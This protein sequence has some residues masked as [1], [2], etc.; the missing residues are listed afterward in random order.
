MSRYFDRFS[1]RVSHLSGTAHA[2]IFA[3]ALI[4]LW[5]ASGPW[6][7]YSELWQLSVN[8]ATTIVTFLMV[9]VVQHTQNRDTLALHA[10]L[11]ELIYATK[12]AR[13]DLIEVE[14]QTE[15][16]IQHLR[17]VVAEHNATEAQRLP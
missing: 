11:D 1:T 6:L 3:V 16:E 8:T 15:D 10:K 17:E 4:I 13:N 12:G 5:A 2:F 9:F 7:H 14:S